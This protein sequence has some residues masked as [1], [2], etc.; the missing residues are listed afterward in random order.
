MQIYQNPGCVV[1]DYEQR[2]IQLTGGSTYIISLPIKWVRECG[3]NSGD[4]LT[5]LPQNNCTLLLSADSKIDKKK[6]ECVIQILQEDNLEDNFRILV[7]YYLAGYDLI[8]LVSS[9]GFHALDR[10]F[11][12]DVT[13]QRLIGIEVIEESRN[14]IVLQSLMNYQELPLT[15]GLQNMSRLITSMLEDALIALKGHDLE[16]ARDIV[17]RDNEV[18][19]FYLLTVRQLKSA[20]E[21]LKFAEK[22]GVERPRQCLGYRLVTKIIERIG[23][24]VQRI[25]QQIIMMDATVPEKD[26]V[27]A[28]GTLAQKV[29][30]D[31][32]KALEEMDIKFS[33]KVVNL[34]RKFEDYTAMRNEQGAARCKSE[35]MVSIIDSLKR[36][37]EY[38]ADIAEMS[39]NMSSERDRG[40]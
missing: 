19:R 38:S 29:F 37:S 15:K 40:K 35:Q 1:I 36:I 20:V 34:A 9:K 6:S 23:D 3:L 14:E 28:M 32:M 11:F 12:K 2:K 31:S 21:D 30:S 10:K 17:S 25:A 22:I 4:T 33:N 7:S 16:L 39:I 18:D 13:R 5:L 27:F 26:A 8:R 24:H